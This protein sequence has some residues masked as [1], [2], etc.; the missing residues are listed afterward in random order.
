MFKYDVDGV[1]QMSCFLNMVG[2]SLIWQLTDLV[3]V[4]HVAS[5]CG[6]QC[7]CHVWDSPAALCFGQGASTTNS[8]QVGSN[9]GL[10]Y[11]FYMI[12]L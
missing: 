5:D 10:F 2:F 4:V 6:A 1:W 11:M 12:W 8:S 7:S 9:Y 3:C